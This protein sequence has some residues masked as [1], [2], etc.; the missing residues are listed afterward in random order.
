[1]MIVLDFHT[2]QDDAFL[3]LSF[4]EYLQC[5]LENL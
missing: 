4:K 1:M 3:E 2:V 5:K